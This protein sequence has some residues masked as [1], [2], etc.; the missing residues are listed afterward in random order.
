PRGAGGRGARLSS[1]THL[2]VAGAAGCPARARLAT[3]MGNRTGRRAFAGA[4]ERGVRHRL[5]VSGFAAVGATAGGHPGV[6][7][8]E[9]PTARRFARRR[10][11]SGG[12]LVRVW[13]RARHRISGRATR[14]APS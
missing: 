6:P 1:T 8:L 2:L 9:L 12:L 14:T 7:R 4:E 13:H 11:R 3:A 5:V 10:G